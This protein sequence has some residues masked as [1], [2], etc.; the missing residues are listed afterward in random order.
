MRL[1]LGAVARLLLR[2]AAYGAA[3]CFAAALASAILTP[4]PSSAAPTVQGDFAIVGPTA[5]DHPENSADV[6]ATYAVS[7]GAPGTAVSWDVEG[8]DARRFAINAAGALRFKS[9]RD[10]EKP[11]DGNKDNTYEVEVSAAAGSDYDFVEITVTVTDVNE[12]PSFEL[13]AA[14]LSVTENAAA[15]KR[16]GGALSVTDPDDGDTWTF[17]AT[18][19][20]ADSF[21][22]DTSGQIRVRAGA[23]L[24]YEDAPSLSITATVTDA[25]GLSDSLP[26]TI[27]L[28]DADDPGVVTFSPAS[29]YV[30]TAFTV[31]VH[32]D[33]GVTGRIR[34]RWHR[35][36]N[37][38]DEFDRIDNATKSTYMPTADDQGYVL[39]ATVTYEDSFEAS[40]SASAI[41]SA[42][43]ANAP[44]DFG[45]ETAS[46]T[47]SGG[48]ARGT[49]IGQP[50]TA[51][52]ED[53]DDLTYT[54]SG[55]DA[56]YFAIGAATGQ[57][58]VGVD[59]L[60]DAVTKSSYSVTVTATDEPGA[61]DTITVTITATT[62]NRPPAITGSASVSYTENG[63]S[64]VATY[65][66]SDPDGDD[67][68]WSVAGTDA[69]RFSIS[70]SGV[71]SF[72]SSPDYE[73][74]NDGDSDNVYEA[75]VRAS[76]GS[77]TST[78][79][80]EVTVTDVNESGSITGSAS[81][82]YAENGTSVVAAYT[83]TDPDGDD[84]TWS[85]A[86]TD[87]AR[88]SIS[89]SGVLSFKSSPDYESPNDGNDDNVY[90]VTVRASDGS[91]TSTLDV[92]VTVT[93]V[94]ESPTVTG[95]AS[96]SYAE[97][98]TG[99]VATYTATDPDGDEVTWSVAGT[100]AA[101]FSISTSGVLSFKSSPDYESPND[102]NDDNVYEVTVR[103]SDGSLTSTLDVE[104][105][106]TD[107]NESPTV[108]GSASVSYGE[109]GT[110]AV[111]TYAATDPEGD[112]V[113]WSVAGRD[114]A[115]FSI[116]TSGVLSFKSSPDYESPSDSDS[117]NVYEVTAHA[118]DGSLTSTLDVEVTV[119]DV[120]ESGSITGSVS[121]S[122]AENGTGTVGTYKATD[123]DGDD[124]T[125][126]LTGT[127]AARFSI[128]TAGVLSFKSS[129]DYESP[130]DGNDDNVY[131]VT[132]RAS[133]GSLTS[134]LDV[135]ITV[136]DVN[137]SGSITGSASVS[138]AENGTGGVATYTATDPDGDEVTWSV[139]GTDTARFS[140]STTGV[141]SFKSSPDYES[142]NDGDDDNVYELTIRASDGSLT[143]ALDVEVTVT[144]I[145]ESGSITGSASVSYAENGTSVVAAYTVTDPDGDDVTWSLA[146][147]DAVRFSI[148][149]S[150]QLS[151]KSSPDYESP[152]DGDSDNVYEVTV[153]ASDG[154]LTST[155]DVDITV[156][157]VNES[158]V[159]T[160]S[161]SVSYA[162]NGT[163]VVAAYTV[164]DPDGDDVTWSLA[165]TDAARFS[166]SASGQLSFKSSPDYE[167]PNDG[168][169]DNVYEVTVRA[170]DGSLT[171]TLDVE[172]TVTDVNE[173]GA[174]AGPA[175]VNYVENGTGVVA[176]YTVTDPDGDDVTWSVVGTDA[177]R[178]S[179]STAGAVSFKSSPDYE[180]PNDG[181]DD[182][183]YELTVRASDGSLT[184]TLDV[185]ITVTNVNESGSITGSASVSYA[186][187]GTSI[188]ATYTASD[189]DGDE[190]TWSV[191]GTDAARFSISTTGAVS[192]KSSPDYES[193][194][195]GN[196]DNVYEVTLRASDGSLT[197]RLD[198]DI[199]VT[200]LNE[201][202]SITGPASVNY[203]ENGTGAVATYTATDPDGDDVTWSIAGTDAARFSISTTGV[204]SFKSSPD[205]ESPNDGDSD[206]VYEVTVRASD[207]SLTSK[208]DVEITVTDVNESSSITG[209]AS[210]S[211]AENGTGA[212][213]TYTATDPEGDGVT[214][215]VGGTDAARF[216]ISTA[217]SLSFKSSPDYESPNDANSDN[218]YEVTARA[219]DGS[220]TST[221]D[222][223]VTVTD[224]NESDAI[225]G[226][227]SVSYAENGT[228][229][230]GT[231]TATDPEGDAVT[232]SM[233]GTDAARFSIS[234][235]GGLSFKSSP[236]YESPDD[237][238]SDNVYEVT[239]RASDGSLTSTLD[240]E[241]TVTDVNESSVI[242]GSAS[243]S[244]AENGTGAVATY[245]VTDP[246]GDDVT[247]SVGGTD[248]ARFSISTAGVLS[249]K[250]SP[251]YES[252]NDAN[253]DNV[254]EVTIRASDGS[255]ASK[256]DV[257]ITVTDIN[258]SSTITGSASV[259]YAENSTDTVGTYT[260]T[261]P[262]G[263]DVTWSVMGMDTAWF[264]ISITG[265][266]SFKSSPDHESPN[267]GDSD[268]VYEVTIHASDGNLTSTLDVEVTVTDVNESGA[269]TGPASM[270]Y[271]ENGTGTVAT[272]SATDP[273]GDDVTWSVEGTDAARFS[274][275][276]AGQLSFKSS[277]D[278]E[279]PNDGNDDN[280][281]EVTVRASDGSLASTLDVE[282]TVTDVNESP[283]V[284]GPASVS[285]AE[286][287]GDSVAT[288]SAVDPEGDDVTWSIAGTDAA[289]FAID[290]D[291]VLTFV[292][293][294]NF[295]QPLDED[296]DNTY[297]VEIAAGQEQGNT[298]VDVTVTITD[299]NDA[300]RFAVPTFAVQIPENSC[301]GAHTIY[302][303][304]G[305]GERER[306]D[307]D[308]DP[309]T[310]A[311]SGPDAAVFVIHPPTGYV[312]LGPGTLL[313]F[314]AGRKPF[315]LRVSV[316]DGRDDHGNAESEFTPDDYL[317]L[318]VTVGNVDE[319]PGF[320][321]AEPIV[322]ACGSPVVHRASQLRRTVTAGAPGGSPVGDGLSATDPEGETVHFR[323]VSQSDAGAFAIDS[324]SGQ[325]M[326]APGF[327]PRDARRVY[328]VRVA[329]TDGELESHIEVRIA[330][331]TAPQPAPE[332]DDSGESSAAN[333]E[334]VSDVVVST[335]GQGVESSEYSS[336][337]G[338]GAENSDSPPK[339][340]E[341]PLVNLRQV[342]PEFVPVPR[343]V[344]TSLFRSSEV[345]DQTDRARLTA[346]A[347]TLAVP[348]QVRLTRD[349]AECVRLHET[350]HLLECVC[351][352]VEFFDVAGEPLALESLNRPAALEVVLETHGSVTMMMRRGDGQEWGHAHA[353]VSE[354]AKGS[355]TLIAR[356]KSPGQYLALVTESTTDSGIEG[357]DAGRSGPLDFVKVA[358][359]QG[360]QRT[361]KESAVKRA[362]PFHYDSAAAYPQSESAPNVSGDSKAWHAA[363]LL[364][365][366]LLDVTV[367][368]FAGF[369]LY[370]ITFG[371]R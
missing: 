76:D 25:G 322:N 215:S 134:T 173:S 299:A 225:T 319:P 239:V 77:L 303:G 180:S 301:P 252:P 131:E 247:W 101:R 315:T 81:V 238:D 309:L 55:N 272:Y 337:L 257:E 240:V 100:D 310:Y 39:R 43:A 355:P 10:Y 171:S 161:A 307:E 82:S 196:D 262:D 8:A 87:A 204:L 71:L 142:P 136:T 167:S 85:L 271:A 279:S 346:P 138:Y 214:W 166:I 37:A 235:T 88:F 70:T 66:A 98:G 312:T 65:A 308:G 14:A 368:L 203:A 133:D 165:G 318:T 197:S 172:V 339:T 53:G 41:S 36:Q 291:G 348:F 20:S 361:I 168:D 292:E 236:D 115:R 47:A 286:N 153:R 328:T 83:V 162:E 169:S 40:T 143:S 245:T 270:S 97:N 176:T 284:T 342:E 229:A 105:T 267:D 344:Q 290:D 248:A 200:D 274:I 277:P 104:V 326:V 275:S 367:T 106:V 189:P 72:K 350:A 22:I 56:Q 330:V 48:A 121:V 164:T 241:I 94:N 323:I 263:D 280:V 84:V 335:S 217:G 144:D 184:S 160:G 256:L 62:P 207:G 109:N 332:P 232:W 343:A 175:T 234:T 283:I 327:S 199:T 266:L 73:S 7:G 364:I 147:T 195:D 261:D 260:A 250:S 190:V 314:E 249:F 114:A 213:A 123:P 15:N 61:T 118:S 5:N 218:V 155:L 345:Q 316:S 282:I 18:G 220:L 246:E 52:D 60:P 340:L 33:D 210:V 135:E 198:V 209:S 353:I 187:N 333:V 255:L 331:A 90:E 230:V 124:V 130:N 11:N 86:G 341:R 325:I 30:G 152:N 356:I 329:V 59:N 96:V 222:V 231:Y 32:D 80:V 298:G 38:D 360:M 228:G 288:Y 273:D 4:Q 31:A 75:T 34:W 151:F 63:T 202:G 362:I 28:T 19:Q 68:T 29:P 216:S 112:D 223:E 369:L 44:P 179:I 366:L 78:L 226:S 102:G 324:T 253:S 3:A 244:Y 163:S 92:E 305:G 285:F 103:A 365:A 158:V 370:R 191:A 24:D 99:G 117:D 293:T 304:I 174:I 258:E 126:S 74:P 224:V 219:S 6:I 2:S 49:N 54:L 122:Y 148:S 194:N 221:L 178:F 351:I 254:Y 95:S 46:R 132:V 265:A 289:R 185:E 13:D 212:V 149:A 205:Y 27:T 51:T 170:S 320:A 93:D 139:A 201:S 146:G 349:D 67:V 357:E 26:V 211:Y 182:N 336:P 294:P 302:R 311:L 156:T 193:P 233:A 188:V 278:Y 177:A 58:T 181:D 206:N 321:E 1:R 89:T 352:A 338:G 110:S 154:S 183:V 120:N 129:P 111:A 287:G 264:A 119:T 354:P 69:A 157:D 251:N 12:A 371:Q 268:N 269:I 358:A 192:F 296:G 116:S 79:D 306:T 150:G 317:D 313:D 242:T 23:D 64:A 259:S 186:E 57:I 107:V 91:L 140:I 237:G 300:P 295:E 359:A 16:V 108:T 297:E 276:A 141:L 334:S 243:V 208:L 128:S 347:G 42:V 113:T 127:D 35:A 21:S 9:A 145:N 45:A 17:S 363:R 50:L 159:I 227:A 281:Y 137:E 125:W